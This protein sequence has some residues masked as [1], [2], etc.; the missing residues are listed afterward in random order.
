MTKARTTT[1]ARK[2]GRPT[3]YSHAVAEEICNLIA[4][5]TPLRV[6][7]R[8][9]DMPAWRTVYQWLDRHPEF[10][11]RFARARE[12]GFDA[13]AEEALEIANTPTIGEIEIIGPDGRTVRREDM[14]GHRKLQVEARLKLLAK[15]A[16]KKYG[17]KLE[18]G[19]Q[20]A[21]TPV[22]NI[23]SSRPRDDA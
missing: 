17:E 9:A 19:G 1:T 8:R 10:Q 22:L 16:P 23:S 18:L 6:I 20:M 5:G 15:W 11:A 4:E 3:T 12:L 14:L 2:R 13:I 21:V 7:C